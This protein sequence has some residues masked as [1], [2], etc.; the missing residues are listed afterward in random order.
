MAIV[1]GYAVHAIDEDELGVDPSLGAQRRNGFDYAS[2]LKRKGHAA[3]GAPP[4]LPAGSADTSN[5]SG[6]TGERNGGASGL[7]QSQDG[8]SD[9]ESVR[10]PQAD[11]DGGAEHSDGAATGRAPV[12][13]AADAEQGR[14]A[15]PAQ[16]ESLT[17]QL[18]RHDA[19]YLEA[20]SREQHTVFLLVDYLA[21][22]VA[23]F[24][25]DPAVL[26]QGHWS[27]SLTL[28]PSIL[29][30]CKLSLTLSH[31]DL[32]LRFDTGHASSKQIV[33]HHGDVLKCRLEAL[34]LRHDAP[35]TVQI[36]LE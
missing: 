16:T 6:A 10:S 25:S 15:P 7:A 32:V 13:P 28:D 8:A 12:S 31:F 19:P 14:K 11:Q 36:T 29:P 33:L 34:L 3:S 30:E 22:R 9:S 17:Q 1:R 4:R 23:D 27:M 35:R 18:Q 20:L 24:C 5:D 2:L 21:A 26:A